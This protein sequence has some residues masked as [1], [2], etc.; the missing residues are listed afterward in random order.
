[1]NVSDVTRGFSRDKKLEDNISYLRE[2]NSNLVYL[3]VQFNSNITNRWELRRKFVV[4]DSLTAGDDGG[5]ED[6][7]SG[8]Y[9]YIVN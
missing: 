9:V 8:I 1:M 4:V 6:V 3:N 7:A 5:A 2:G